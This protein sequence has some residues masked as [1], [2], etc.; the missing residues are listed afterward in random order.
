MDINLINKINTDNKK[1]NKKN[2]KI[3]DKSMIDSSSSQNICNDDS[4]FSENNY[5]LNGKIKNKDK[6]Q[7]KK[8]KTV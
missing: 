2:K 7:K 6:K 4:L 5:I 3:I 1:G 8:F